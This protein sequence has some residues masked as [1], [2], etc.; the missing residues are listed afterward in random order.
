ADI[1]AKLPE[2]IRPPILSR[3]GTM[4]EIPASLVE[5]IASALASELPAL[6]SDATR[7]VEGLER[8]AALVR[9]L[10]RELGEEALEQLEDDN[11]ELAD[12]IRQAMYTFDDLAGLDAGALRNVLEGVSGDKLTLALKTSHLDVTNA[13]FS[14]MSRRAADRIREDLEMLGAVRLADV[15]AAQREIVEV[16]TRLMAEGVI[17]LDNEGQSVV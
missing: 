5:E 11:E 8:A 10:G 1:L 13:I 3:L 4:T 16:A 7:Q 12:A 2:R 17:S 6:D 15:E 9:R 14:S